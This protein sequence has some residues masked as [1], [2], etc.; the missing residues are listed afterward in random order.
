M[1]SVQHPE[2]LVSQHVQQVKEMIPR[3]TKQSVHAFRLKR[4]RYQVTTGNLRHHILPMK[5]PYSNGRQHSMPEWFTPVANRIS[6]S[7]S[8]KNTQPFII[9]D[10][11]VLFS[12]S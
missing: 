5:I 6:G 8:E 2:W 12:K 9:Y 4:L 10:K 7:V 3:N 1:S 11:F